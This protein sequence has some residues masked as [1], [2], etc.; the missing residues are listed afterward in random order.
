[1]QDTALNSAP[2]LKSVL[3]QL[4]YGIVLC[5]ADMRLQHAN[6]AAQRELG[7][8]RHV[9]VRGGV[10][11][12][13]VAACDRALRLA[14]RNAARGRRGLIRLEAAGASLGVAVVP[15]DSAGDGGAVMLVL[16]RSRPCES[17]S[18]DLF[19]RQA[20]I[21]AAEASV[22]RSLCDGLSPQEISEACGIA[23]CTVRTHISA[24]RQKTG[25]RNISGLVRL[26][27]VLPPVVPVLC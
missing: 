11:R 24:L 27:T 4:D 5:D 25:V 17:L 13:I 2:I 9:A 16:G 3:D 14:V 15:L 21:T 19:A 22:L 26:T 1:M 12:A 7:L 6:R 23:I 8:E 10:V 20:G 18:I